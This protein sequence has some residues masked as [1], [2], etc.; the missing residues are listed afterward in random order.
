MTTVDRPV[1]RAGAAHPEEWWSILA[2]LAAAGGTAAFLWKV[3][4]FEPSSTLAWLIPGWI[5]LAYLFI[6]LVCLLVSATQ[7]RALARI[8]HRIECIEAANQ[9]KSL[10]RSNLS[11]THGAPR[12]R[13]S[14][15]QISLNL[16]PWKDAK[17]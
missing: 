15:A 1:R 16:H 17:W 9:R 10:C 3:P 14:V 4:D 11:P 6:Q 8:S 5:A 7:I 12:C 13:Q 2:A